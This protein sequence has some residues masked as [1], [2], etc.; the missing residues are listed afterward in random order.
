MRFLFVNPKVAARGQYYDFPLGLAYVSA[1]MR[2]SGYATYCL[3]LCHSDRPIEKQVFDAV[4]ENNVDVICTGGMSVNFNAIHAVVQAARQIRPDIIVVVGGAVVTADPA[5]ASEL[6]Q[7][8]FGVIGE[9][10]ITMAEL[11]RTLTGSG[12]VAQ[13]DGL[14]YRAA[15]EPS[16]TPIM[17]PTK[18]YVTTEPRKPIMD[19]DSLPFPDCK[20]FGYDEYLKTFAPNCSNNMFT[21]NDNPRG[22]FV[23][24]SRSCPFDCTFCYHPIGRKY[25]QRS[26]ANVMAEIDHMKRNYDVNILVLMDE[27]FSTST[28]RLLLFCKSVKAYHLQ[29]IVQLRVSD[30][31]AKALGAMQASGAYAISYGVESMSD[32]ILKSMNK[33]TT[34]AQI[35]QALAMTRS[36]GIGIFANL[37][38]GDPA[39]TDTTVKKSLDWWFAHIDYGVTLYMI[40]VIPDS[41]IYR[42]ALK[43]GLIRDKAK[44]MRDG[45]PIINISKLSRFAFARLCHLIDWYTFAK[46]PGQPGR[47]L[48]SS[49]IGQD[50][51]GRRTF[52]VDIQC[53]QCHAPSTYTNLAQ[54][55]Y[56]GFRG[57]LQVFCRHC[58]HRVNV[59]PKQVYAYNYK[60]G[61]NSF[62]R[63]ILMNSIDLLFRSRVVFTILNIWRLRFLNIHRVH[64]LFRNLAMSR[65][66]N[67]GPV[68]SIA[69]KG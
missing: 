52:A 60:L 23:L 61:C 5:L 34:S 65:S 35:D 26:I 22:A 27:L 20:G 10:E 43:K 8:D 4:T 32:E 58:H 59:P 41:P 57:Y 54:M 28:E 19:L 21:I 64:R 53:P 11:A 18:V 37:I 49:M 31:T 9:G 6:L 51:F 15:P 3:N 29:W 25:R 55:D 45:F 67:E 62:G 16:R 63:F 14:I 46:I 42:H 7:F 38:F 1:Y 69:S 36:A 44:F 68:L 50:V 2:Q 39:E 24:A 47:V 56:F 30:V 40:R 17:G 48:K 33:K 12:D 66:K 13:V